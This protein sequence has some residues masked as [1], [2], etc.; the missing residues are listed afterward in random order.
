[1]KGMIVQQDWKGSH[2]QFHITPIQ[3]KDGKISKDNMNKMDHIRFKNNIKDK[4]IDLKSDQN[5][6]Y[7]FEY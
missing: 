5:G 3:S 6:G 2:N 1:Q 4:S 7:T